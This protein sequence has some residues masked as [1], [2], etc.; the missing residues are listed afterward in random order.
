MFKDL[1]SLNIE[2]QIRK[3]EII[4]TSNKNFLITAINDDEFRFF[5]IG[6]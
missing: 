3:F 6:N 1:K 5:E 4:N 2:G